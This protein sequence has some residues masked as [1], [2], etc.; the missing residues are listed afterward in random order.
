M[1]WVYPYFLWALLVLVIPIIIHFFNIR[2]YKKIYFS[3]VAFIK[4]ITQESQVKNKIKEYL[5]LALRL[6]ALCFLVMAFA[7]PV[8]KKK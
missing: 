4:Q 1:Q 3:N 8:M 7:Q 6:L 2:R 5:V